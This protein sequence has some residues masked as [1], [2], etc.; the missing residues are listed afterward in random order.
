ME[1]VKNYTGTL[2]YIHELEYST[3]DSIFVFQLPRATHMVSKSYAQEIRENL[4]RLFP[5]RDILIVPGDVNIYEIA[6]ED[7]LALKLK[8]L[9]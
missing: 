5:D 4:K 7:I 2:G 3:K 9:L 8:G 6:G 1:E